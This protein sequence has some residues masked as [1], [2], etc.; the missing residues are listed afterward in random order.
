MSSGALSETRKLEILEEAQQIKRALG[1]LAAEAAN[2]R[3]YEEA[4]ALELMR[5]SV[6]KLCHDAVFRCGKEA[7]SLSAPVSRSHDQESD[8]GKGNA[9]LL[10]NG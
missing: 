3:R 5:S 8:F 6:T 2:Q 1:K 7:A 4:E 9:E 10:S